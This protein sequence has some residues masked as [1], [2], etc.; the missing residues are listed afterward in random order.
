MRAPAYVWSKRTKKVDDDASILQHS[1][2]SPFL[3]KTLSFLFLFRPIRTLKF[4][5]V[6]SRKHKKILGRSNIGYDSIYDARKAG[7]PAAV[8]SNA[9]VGW[10]HEFRAS[11]APSFFCLGPNNRW[12][13]S[14]CYLQESWGQRPT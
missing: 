5:S 10:I 1:Q 7:V 11:R 4:Y 12:L 3:F 6:P 14:S 9:R 13:P 2:R 8:Q